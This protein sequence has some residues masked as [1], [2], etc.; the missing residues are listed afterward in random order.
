MSISV[1]PRATTMAL[2][3]AV[4]FLIFGVDRDQVS[5]F[6]GSDSA[7]GL[8]GDVTRTDRGKNR[9]GLQGCEV[10]LALSGNQLSE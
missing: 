1:E 8:P 2:S 10:L 3:S 7:T 9:L 6:L 4:A 5:E